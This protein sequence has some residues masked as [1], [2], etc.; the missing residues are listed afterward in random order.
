MSISK[1]RTEANCLAS[2]ARQ[3]RLHKLARPQPSQIG[4]DA[5]QFSWK[6]RDSEVLPMDRG[7]LLILKERVDEAIE[8]AS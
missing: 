3:H 2:A 1:A 8:R 7:L 4:F 5:L 6:L